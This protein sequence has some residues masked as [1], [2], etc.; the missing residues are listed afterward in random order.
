VG[1]QL[2]VKTATTIWNRFINLFKEEYPEPKLVLK[3]ADDQLRK[4]GL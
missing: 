4:V 3:M 1:Q 2:S